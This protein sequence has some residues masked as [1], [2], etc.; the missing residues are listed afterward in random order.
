MV[1]VSN[2]SAQNVAITDD[3]GYSA[4]ASAML[5]VKSTDKGLL[6]PRLT[7]AQRNAIGTPATGLMIYQTNITPGFYY[8]NGSGWIEV[9]GAAAV[10]SSEDNLRIIRGTVDDFGDIVCGEGFTVTYWGFVVYTVYFTTA[11]SE[12]PTVTA[13]PYGQSSSDYITIQIGNTY[14]TST[15]FY[16]KEN[17]EGGYDWGFTFIAIGPK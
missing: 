9:R 10:S 2:L 16:T 5:D 7:Q 3:S 12:T 4:D 11:F 1:G 8:Y 15:R 17:T 13:T 6:I 14:E